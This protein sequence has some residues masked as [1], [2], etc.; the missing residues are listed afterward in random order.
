MGATARSEALDAAPP[1]ITPFLVA[2]RYTIADI[3]LYAYTHVANEGG[4]EGRAV[5]GDRS[6]GWN[7]SPPSP[8]TSRSRT[9]RRAGSR[10]RQ[11]YGRDPE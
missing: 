9:S 2:D 7:A 11:G 10:E 6:P 4:F 5:P 1:E 3:S 8:A